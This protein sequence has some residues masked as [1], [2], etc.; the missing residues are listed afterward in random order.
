MLV[1]GSGYSA[2]T[3]GYVGPTLGEMREKI[4][5]SLRDDEHLI[6]PDPVLDD[7]IRAAT[8]EVSLVY[9][10]ELIETMD[11]V[12]DLLEY[13]IACEQVF[14]V[15][16]VTPSGAVDEVPK[17]D[18]DLDV[19]WEIFAGNLFLPRS[20]TFTP[21]IDAVRVWGYSPRD[22]A[23]EPEDTVD[24]DA[25][26]EEALRSYATVM[27]YQALAGDRSLFTQWQALPTN[28][29]VSITQ[30]NALVALYLDRWR[31]VRRH[32]TRL[33]RV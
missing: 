5:R 13:P 22:V 4:A 8:I 16:H 3:Y 15:E 20:M 14:R 29:D 9:P 11:L 28:T 27:G 10:K 1:F 6:F 23:N 25:P 24:V 18:D 17:G 19:G 2:V 30:I 33:R 7:F 31:D 21:D 12:A 26:G 32:L